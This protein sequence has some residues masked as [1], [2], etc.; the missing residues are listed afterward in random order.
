MRTSWRTS[1]CSIKTDAIRSPSESVSSSVSTT[2]RG[3]SQELQ[4][5]RSCRIG[6]A[7]VRKRANR[8]LLVSEH[9]N[10][11]LLDED[12]LAN[13][14]L[15][16]QDGRDSLAIRIRLILSKH[17]LEGKES[18]V[19]GVQELQNWGGSGKEARK[20]TIASLRACQ[21]KPAR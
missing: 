1:S 9:V 16:H 6:A 11:G 20:S 15:F 2:S 12:L 21:R 3:R 8:R 19:A 7:Q 5:F 17:D 18:G 4:E 10:I 13:I 14:E